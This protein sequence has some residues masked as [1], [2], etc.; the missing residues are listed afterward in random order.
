M[1][2]LVEVEVDGSPMR[3]C[4]AS[5][6]GDGPFPAVLVTIHGGG[7][8]DFEFDLA[9]KLASEGYISA[10]PDIFHRQPEGLDR[11]A[12]REALTDDGLIADANAGVAWL[13]STGRADLGRAAILGHCMGGRHAYLGASVNPVY[14]CVVAYYGGNMFVPWGHDGLSPF[15]RLSNLKVPVIGFYGNDDVNPSPDDV[16]K[17]DAELDKLGVTHEFHRYDGAGHAFQNFMSDESYREGP[18]KDSWSRTVAFLKQH[19]G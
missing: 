6:S 18:T 19:I 9:D 4:T 10:A 7:I 2:E 16:N 17:I 12:K 15:D 13:E 11:T 5:P 14:R 8:D 3:I 1:A